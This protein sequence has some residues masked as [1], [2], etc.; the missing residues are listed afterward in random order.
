MQRENDGGMEGGQ[1]E[2]AL[3]SSLTH[4]LHLPHGVPEPGSL[5]G[6]DSQLPPTT[7]LTLSQGHAAEY[8]SLPSA[9]AR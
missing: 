4:T 2:E 3:Q 7:V 1:G 5:S 9:G 8:H 6:G